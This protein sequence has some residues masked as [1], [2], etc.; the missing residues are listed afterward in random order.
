[1]P[2]FG[3][4]RN[5]NDG[6][7]NGNTPPENMPPEIQSPEIP[8]VDPEP[9]QQPSV[10]GEQRKYETPEG[11]VFNRYFLAERRITLENISYEMQHVLKGPGAFKLGVNDTFLSQIMP[12]RGVK[13]TFNRLLKFDPDGPFSLS[14]TYACILVFNPGTKDEVDWTKIDMV[15]EFRQNCPE[16]FQTMSSKMTLLIAEITNEATGTPFLHLPR[17]QP[18]QPKGK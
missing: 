4:N 10:N 2:F 5:Q 12:Q 15:R 13:I 14:V 16:L 11:F 6:A 1:M 9:A 8:A 17:P 3:K 18:P 7:E